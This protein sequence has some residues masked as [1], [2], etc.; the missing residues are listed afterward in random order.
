MSDIKVIY[1]FNILLNYA[2]ILHK[3]IIYINLSILFNVNI[4]HIFLN[5]YNIL[6]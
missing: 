1:L 6:Y 4:L 5:A 3:N 2:H